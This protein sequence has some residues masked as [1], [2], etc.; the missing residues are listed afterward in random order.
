MTQVMSEVSKRVRDRRV[1]PL[2]RRF[3]KAGAMKHDALHETGEGVPQGGPLS[4]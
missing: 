1:L 3:L 2:I 4:P